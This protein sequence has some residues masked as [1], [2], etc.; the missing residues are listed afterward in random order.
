MDRCLENKQEKIGMFKKIKRL[1]TK[2]IKELKIEKAGAIN[3]S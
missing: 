3:L 2:G 1:F